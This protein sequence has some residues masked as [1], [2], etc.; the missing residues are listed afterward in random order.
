VAK[1]E[2]PP[3]HNA[4]TLQSESEASSPASTAAGAEELAQA[5]GYLTGKYGSRNSSEAARYLW[6]AVSKENP[7][8]ILLLSDLYLAGDGVPKSCDQARLLLRAA[9]RKNVAAAAHKLRELQQT[10]CP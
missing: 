1:V 3:V 2:P 5:E 8:A 10:G 6:K 9:A 7:T 4:S